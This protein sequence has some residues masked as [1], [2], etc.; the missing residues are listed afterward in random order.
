[1]LQ[2]V[3]KGGHVIV[4]TFACDGPDH[5]SGLDMVCYSPENLHDEF[6]EGFEIVD[7]THETHHTPFETEQ[8]FIYCYCRKS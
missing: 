6:G 5:C 8:K 2:T 1:M 4:A 7:S 3:R